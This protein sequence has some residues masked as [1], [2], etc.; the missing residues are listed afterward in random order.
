M[1][2]DL[3]HAS[4][5]ETVVDSTPL[6]VVFTDREGIVRLW[7]HGAEVMFGWTA[8]DTLGKS[9]DMMVPEK[10]KARHWEGYDRVMQTGETKYGREVLS[11]P[12]LTKDGRRISIEFN[13]ALVKDNDGHVLGAAATINDVS[14]RWERDKALRARLHELETKLKQ[15][16]GSAKAAGH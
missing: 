10:H 5:C 3:S 14:A 8:E 2:A 13:I 15:L 1:A 4:L 9:M 16:E 12:A 6:A 11:V 7:N